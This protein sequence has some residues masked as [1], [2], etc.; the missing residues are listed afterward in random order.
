MDCCGCSRCGDCHRLSFAFIEGRDEI[1]REREREAPI[2][3]A[4]RISRTPEGDI[5]VTIDRETQQRMGLETTEAAAESVQ[6]EVAAYGRVQEDPD[7]SFVVRAPVSGMVRTSGRN[8][9]TIGES[10]ADSVSIGTIEPR[11]APIERVD[12]TTRLSD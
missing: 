2:K 5:V 1:A 11:L 4:P 12:L 8:W 7:A 3:I 9:P 10:L 6:P